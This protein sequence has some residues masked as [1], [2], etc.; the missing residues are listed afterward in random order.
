VLRP[1]LTVTPGTDRQLA[2]RVLE[3]A[4]KTCLVSASL[5]TSIRMEPHISEQE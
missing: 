1:T 3:K 2:L 5:S 4:G